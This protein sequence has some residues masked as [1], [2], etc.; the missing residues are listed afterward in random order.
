MQ[1][2][3]Y[4]HGNLRQSLVS[5]GAELLN[6]R[7]LTGISLREIA[8]KIGVGHNAPYRH[9]RN[10]QELLEA[11][12]ED[13]FRRLKARNT[14]L[15]LEFAHDPEAQLFESGMHIVTMAAEQPD[16]FQLMFGGVL[17]PKDCGESLKLEVDAAMISLTRII[18]SGQKQ[19]VFVQG[20][21][22]KLALSAMSMVQGL[23]LM[24]SSGKLGMNI[25]SSPQ[26][27]C[28]TLLRGMMLQLFD[29]FLLGIKQQTQTVASEEKKEN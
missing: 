24:V 27:V 13:G 14:R 16:L 26:P 2:A 18:Q 22:T 20:D 19:Q 25:K 8:R 15:E 4:H 11:I 23:A 17:R 10:K 1:Q 3:A 12:A 7:G 5:M 9:F 29:V 28:Q 21:P 6:T